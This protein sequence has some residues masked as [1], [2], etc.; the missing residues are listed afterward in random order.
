MK[1]IQINHY[2]PAR[3]NKGRFTAKLPKII[4]YTSMIVA[5]LAIAYFSQ[6]YREIRYVDRVQEKTVVINTTQQIIDKEKSD[7][8]DSLEQCESKGNA[9]A[10]NW[11]DY[12]QGCNRAS[13]GAYMFKV[14]TIQSFIKGLTAFQAIAL[15]SDKNESRKL[16]SQIIFETK[17][18]I[19]N[20]KNCMIKNGLLERVNFVKELENKIVK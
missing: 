6:N 18:G 15:A 4:F 11:E 16:A 20:W 13:F 17:D 10:I 14:G 19:Y 1:K 3:D 9:N 12:G 8:L 7:I 5:I 2:L